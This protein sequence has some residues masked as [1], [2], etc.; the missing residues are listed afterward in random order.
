MFSG[1][2]MPITLGT[3]EWRY[4][5]SSQ[6]RL[7]KFQLQTKCILRRSAGFWAD[8]QAE[9][10]T[11]LGRY[12]IRHRIRWVLEPGNVVTKWRR[13]TWQ[14]NKCSNVINKITNLLIILVE[15]MK[16]YFN[17]KAC[18]VFCIKAICTLLL[19]SDVRI[20]DIFHLIKFQCYILKG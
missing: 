18:N 15:M 9:H 5:K 3:M 8:Y 12:I 14:W 11:I 4:P 16:I 20:E 2:S 6:K 1:N 13:L 19:Q 10:K 17:T 7:S